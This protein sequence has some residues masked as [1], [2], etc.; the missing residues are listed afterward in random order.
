MGA[1]AWPFEME[2]AGGHSAMVTVPLRHLRSGL[3]WQQEMMCHYLGFGQSLQLVQR[4]L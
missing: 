2:I 4:Y 1:V 3:Y